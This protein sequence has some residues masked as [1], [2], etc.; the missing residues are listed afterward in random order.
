MNPSARWPVAYR[1]VILAGILVVAALLVSQLL[2]LL[3]AALIT[4]IIAIPLASG[5]D[6][7]EG[8]GV[9]RPLG[10]LITLLLALGVLGGVIALIVPSFVHEVNTFVD[11]L[12]TIVHD[13][14][15]RIGHLTG[16]S[17][18]EVGRRA[19]D[20]TNNV[21]NHPGRLLGTAASAA[22]SVAGVLAAVIVILIT[23]V[24][25]AAN[26]RP[27]I[28]GVLRVFPPESRPRVVI[29]MRRLRTAWLGWM[30]GLGIAM[31]LIGVLLYIGLRLLGLEFAVF[32]AV[33]SALAEV[34]PYF[35]AIVSGL[36]PVVFALTVSPGKAL[37]VLGVYVLVHQLE[38]N[39]IQPLIM[40]RAVKLHPAVIA[41]GVVVV[42]EL[43]GIVGL[44]IS[45]PLISGA[46]ILVEELWVKPSEE[47]AAAQ[48]A[49]DSPELG[50]DEFDTLVEERGPA[51]SSR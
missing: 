36:P 3:L 47:R 4:V 45:V 33:L 5:A 35:G 13:A 42:G 11:N 19:K 50:D 51:Q 25:I 46:L 9:P 22:I 1:T 6:W 29:V 18:D 21:S 30:R 41:L 20:F 43:F 27:L 23:A 37:A 14:E 38:G 34:I 16:L 15:G 26:P 32:F 28:S 39:V 31:L 24:Y 44:I 7:L 8:H 17:P 40:A 10:A 48:L 49:A 2:T 12:P